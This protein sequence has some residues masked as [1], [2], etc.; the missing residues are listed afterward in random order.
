MTLRRNLRN[1]NSIEDICNNK[2]TDYLGRHSLI[3]PLLFPNIEIEERL[4]ILH[5][6]SVNSISSLSHLFIADG[7]V[8][9]DDAPSYYIAM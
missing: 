8:V 5:K 4:D 1:P 2:V 6:Q 9:I 7:D 3:G